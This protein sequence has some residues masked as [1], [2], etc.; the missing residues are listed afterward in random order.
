MSCCGPA[1]PTPGC[2]APRWR[3]CRDMQSENG[4]NGRAPHLGFRLH[5]DSWGRL[6]LTD[7]EGRQHAGIEPVRA[8]PLSSP[9]H[10]VSV[11][12]ADGRELFWIDALDELPGEVRK[13]LEDE[14]RRR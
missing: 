8:F 3:S 11:C 14:L 9:R 6:V 10:G 7:T 1:A 12:D 13:I 4:S 5:H 2:T